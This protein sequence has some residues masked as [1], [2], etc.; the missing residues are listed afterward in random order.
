MFFILSYSDVKL[1]YAKTFPYD[2]TASKIPCFLFFNQNKS[3]KTFSY[4]YVF[5]NND[6]N[7]SF[8]EEQ[9]LAIGVRSGFGRILLTHR[10]AVDKRKLSSKK[11]K[12]TITTVK[13]IQIFRCKCSI[14]GPMDPFRKSH[15]LC[16]VY[17][18]PIDQTN[19]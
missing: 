14:Y 4:L 8:H 13:T 18:F 2:C 12:K 7:P 19:K 11:N 16:G 1:F 9:H 15:F 5:D 3:I 10:Q 6:S 17:S